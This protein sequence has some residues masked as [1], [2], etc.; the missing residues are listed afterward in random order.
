[1]RRVSRDDDYDDEHNPKHTHGEPHGLGDAVARI[2]DDQ[3]S[4]LIGDEASAFLAAATA[5][6]DGPRFPI[7]QDAPAEPAHPA[8]PV[9]RLVTSD[10]SFRDET[11]PSTPA[12][13]GQGWRPRL[14]SAGAGGSLIVLAVLAVTAWGQQAVVAVP[15][16]AYGFGWIAYLWWNAALR[17][18]LP[19]AAITVI[20]SLCRAGA[21]FARGTCHLF[22]VGVARLDRRR[23]R[24]ESTRTAIA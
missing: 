19:Q 24:H 1:M 6:A 9:L 21:A 2:P 5:A 17:P 3:L 10:D 11:A 16:M 13:G 23:T 4:D 14:L 20:T 8:K 18:P 7:G 22:A 12:T 15:L